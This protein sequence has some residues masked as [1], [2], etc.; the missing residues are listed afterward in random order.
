MNEKKYYV[1][2]LIPSSHSDELR[3]AQVTPAVTAEQV[4]VYRETFAFPVRIGGV[5]D[6]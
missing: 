3:W 6:D 2:A 4:R 5:A 1:F